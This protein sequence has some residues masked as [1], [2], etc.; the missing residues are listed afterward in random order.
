MSN[1]FIEI[2]LDCQNSGEAK[3]V[4]LCIFKLDNVFFM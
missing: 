3:R 4:N 2:H 1:G